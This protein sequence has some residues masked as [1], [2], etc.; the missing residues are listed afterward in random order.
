MYP[1]GSRSAVLQVETQQFRD[2]GI[3]VDNSSFDPVPQQRSHA[4]YECGDTDGGV[5]GG[6]GAYDPRTLV[7][8]IT[9][10]SA[11]DM[12]YL[13]VG[14]RKTFRPYMGPEGGGVTRDAPACQSGLNVGFRFVTR[15]GC[16]SY[17]V[18]RAQNHSTVLRR[19]VSAC[20]CGSHP[21]C[22]LI[23][24]ISIA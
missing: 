20:S 8:G 16:R 24:V 3:S 18:S 22:V 14:R 19:P 15:W 9:E 2:I 10:C 17:V 1:S 4:R 21:N 7:L 5:V 13:L 11:R 23:L 12:S 6:I